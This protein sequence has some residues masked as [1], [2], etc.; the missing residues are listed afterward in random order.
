[1]KFKEL[2]FECNPSSG[3]YIA[4]QDVLE[5]QRQYI[6]EEGE[7]NKFILHINGIQPSKEP[8]ICES[9]ESAKAS[10]NIINQVYMHNVADK[11]FN[12]PVIERYSM[13]PP[14]DRKLYTCARCGATKS[15]KYLVRVVKSQFKVK[16]CAQDDLIMVKE[17]PLCHVCF[18]L[19]SN[20]RYGVMGSHANCVTTEAIEGLKEGE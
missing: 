8:V 12:N 9:F 2:E 5:F 19:F 14:N 16:L 11:V 15:V 17:V 20:S 7:G 18:A 13:I 1:M 6:I 3:K 4:I 10:A